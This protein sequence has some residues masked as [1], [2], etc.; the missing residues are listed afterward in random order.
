MAKGPTAKE[1]R[2]HLWVMEKPCCVKGCNRPSIA[3]HEKQ[4]YPL[5]RRDHMFVVNICDPHH[6]EL[7]TDLSWRLEKFFDKYGVCLN[8]L[9]IKNR[10][11]YENNS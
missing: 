3:H 6:R 11:E 4:P 8:G 7:H 5:P 2:F 10:E 1:K 9:A